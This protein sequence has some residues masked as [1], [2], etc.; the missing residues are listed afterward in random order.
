MITYVIPKC[1]SCELFDNDD[2]QFGDSF[3][4]NIESDVSSDLVAYASDVCERPSVERT[5][6]LCS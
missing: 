1:S 4:L 3:I 5:D 6:A 2:T